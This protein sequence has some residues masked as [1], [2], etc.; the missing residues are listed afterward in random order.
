V[1]TYVSSKAASLLRARKQIAGLG[2]AQLVQLGSRPRQQRGS[3][4]ARIGPDPVDVTRDARCQA[5]AH[6]FNSNLGRPDTELQRVDHLRRAS[7]I[8]NPIRA[9]T[10]RAALHRRRNDIARPRAITS[11]SPLTATVHRASSHPVAREP[12]SNL[13]VR[14]HRSNPVQNRLACLQCTHDRRGNSRV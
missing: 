11:Y 10:L 9:P 6:G 5:D 1:W 12:R 13:A 14:G 4:R 2:P 7:C 8:T 3:L